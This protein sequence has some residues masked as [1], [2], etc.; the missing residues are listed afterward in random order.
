LDPSLFSNLDFGHFTFSLQRLA[1]N[2]L[3]ESPNK[4][5]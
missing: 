1:K 3:R 4:M 5:G 2:F